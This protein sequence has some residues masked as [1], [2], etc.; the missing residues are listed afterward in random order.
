MAPPA[1]SLAAPLHSSP[2]R[3]APFPQVLGE[4][5][6][7]P[8]HPPEQGL[9]SLGFL[10]GPFRPRVRPLPTWLPGWPRGGS[11][12][13]KGREAAGRLVHPVSTE[14][15]WGRSSSKHHMFSQVNVL[16]FLGY[17][18]SSECW[19]SAFLKCLILVFLCLPEVCLPTSCEVI[20]RMR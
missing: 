18:F 12:D 4:P 8:C 20:H 6:C 1:G 11:R 13:G 15:T 10:R 7:S 16:K 5:A 19:G 14:R 9:R 17:C 3:E 2:R